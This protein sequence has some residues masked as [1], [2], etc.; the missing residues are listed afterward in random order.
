M[1]SV[2]VCT[3]L[4]RALGAHHAWVLDAR[5]SVFLSDATALPAGARCVA[6]L[7]GMPVS[8]ADIRAQGKQARAIG[9]PLV[10]D[11]TQ[12]GM[13][14]CAA[15][16]LGAHVTYAQLDDELWVAGVSRDCTQVLP[17]MRRKLMDTACMSESALQR[18][19]ELMLEADARWRMA[20]DSAQVA[21]A[22]LRCHPRVAEVRYPG[23][24]GDPSFAIA[25][26]TLSRGFG[27]LVDYRLAESNV[28]HR[29]QCGTEE[30][31][32]RILRLEHALARG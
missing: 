25:A 3:D 30:V 6:P 13:L 20:S 32:E 10:V 17:D 19:H 14:A 28:W 24:K 31:H 15:N 12:T 26:R 18:A 5:A 27:P 22:F 21:A 8:C 7:G 23:L 4:A 16:R 2:D 9:V 1:A 11:L 29:E